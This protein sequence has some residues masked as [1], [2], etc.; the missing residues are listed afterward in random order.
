MDFELDFSQ[1]N[2]SFNPDKITP[3]EIKSVFENTKRPRLREL[4]GY[5]SDEFYNIECGYSN[6]K[7]ILLIASRIFDMKRQILQV[8]VADEDEIEYYYCKG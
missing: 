3:I 4:L 6:K 5:P 1:V 2:L 8:K 7:R